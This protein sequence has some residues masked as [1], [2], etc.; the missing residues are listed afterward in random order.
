MSSPI[1][2]KSPDRALDWKQ[3]SNPQGT[4]DNHRPSWLNESHEDLP[5]ALRLREMES[6][7]LRCY[8]KM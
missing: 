3:G 7:S 1:Q 8:G 2:E 5:T 4:G 6:P